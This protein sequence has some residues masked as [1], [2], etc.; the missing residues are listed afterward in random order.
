MTYC[1]TFKYIAGGM[2][3]CL[4]ATQGMAQG[5]LAPLPGQEPAAPQGLSAPP[6]VGQP[7][8]ALP[9]LPGLPGA[10]VDP[11]QLQP[12][13]ITER[14]QLFARYSDLKARMQRLSVADTP[15]QPQTLD[16]IQKAG[17]I[18]QAVQQQALM[19]EWVQSSASSLLQSMSGRPLNGVAALPAGTAIAPRFVTMRLASKSYANPSS[20]QGPPLFSLAEGSPILALASVQSGSW[21]FAW[22]PGS[23]YGYVLQ[24]LTS[25][26]EGE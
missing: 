6:Q 11:N 12:E 17:A 15:A 7:L 22:V 23:G 16:A 20:E 26:L 8:S 14:D 25:P 10:T 9:G 18:Y 5:S 13:L 21:V 4:C 1:N 2:L 24:S 3:L 19:A